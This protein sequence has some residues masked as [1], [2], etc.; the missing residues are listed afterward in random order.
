MNRRSFLSTAAGFPAI[1]RGA[2]APPNVLLITADDMNCDAPGCFGGRVKNITPNIDRLASQ[3]L[4]FERGHVTSAVCQPSRSV[5]MTGRFP[6]RNGAEGFQ[7]IRRDV[8]TLQE[9]LSAAGYRNAILAKNEHLAPKE[10]FCWDTYITPDQLGQGRDPALYYRH[11]KAFL[12]K[13]KAA[14]APFFLMA[15]S[16]D[17]H[18]PF[19]GSDQELKSF[20]KHLDYTRK[21]EPAEVTIPGFLPDLPKVRQEVAEYYTSVHRCDQSVGQVL[22]ALEETGL[23]GNTLVMFL[24]DNGMSFPFSKTNC[25]LASTHT[26]WIAR[27]PG[28]VKPGTVDP[29]HFISGIDF[30]PTILEA[31][32]L[33]P[34]AGVDGSSFVPVLEGRTQPNRDHVV[35]VFHETSAKQR[36][37]MR[38]IQNRRFGYIFNAWSDGKREFKN[39]SQSGR[40]F[41][42]MKEA[43]PTNAAVAARVK[44]FLNRVPEEFYDLAADPNALENLI[45]SRRFAGEIA[46]LRHRLR[47]HL[48]R[49]ADPL[50]A[51]FPA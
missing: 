43:A 40:T 2:G 24:S 37:E 31:A 39:E 19:A 22:R 6:H 36:F 12:E 30:T 14:R 26:P 49:T 42:A 46:A 8:P 50:R 18:R 20:G 29:A 45:G 3:G 16:Q 11:A 51:Q 27:W 10:K 1:L 4:R 25:Y 15:N 44:F 33:A 41:E 32:G 38:A 48:T 9:R 13:A 17:P 35:T 21:V 23:A 47:E 5:L 34:L 7:P 28:R